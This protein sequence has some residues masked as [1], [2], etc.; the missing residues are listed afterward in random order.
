[1]TDQHEEAER[2]YRLYGAYAS[3]YTGKT[4]S[5]LRKKG[6]P[7]EECLPCTPHFRRHVTPHVGNK[8]IP[9]LEAPD[10]TIVQD[11]TEIFDFIEARHPLPPALPTGP[12]QRLIAHLFELFAD[13]LTPLAWHFRWHFPEENLHFVVRDFGRSFRPQGSD[14]ELERYGRVIAD[15][16]E[17][18][19]HSIGITP[20]LFPALDAIYR[21]VLDHLEAH[22]THYP[23][24]LGGLPCAADFALMGPLFAHL[25][26]DPY[27]L[28]VMQRRAPRVFRW[29][30][31]MNTPE[32]R[33]P[34]F[35][36][37]PQAWLAEDAV[38]QD[39]VALLAMLI[40]D[41]GPLYPASA[42]LYNQWVAEHPDLAEDS[43]V[44]ERGEAQPSLGPVELNLRGEPYTCASA[45][46]GLWILQRSLDHL[47]ALGAD[48]KEACVELA[49]TLGAT[50]LLDVVLSRRLKRA[51]YRL[52]VG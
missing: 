15:Q 35:S 25:G 37:L 44:S 40:R 8:R 49:A 10:G 38:P 39:V 1:M 2:P 3:L 6:I 50:Q 11:S 19:G 9:M 34:E 13:A 45:P 26:R 17:G 5:Y 47:A 42:K 23:Y 29:V 48:D 32:L 24:L 22:F 46:H 16:M 28:H 4:R 52:A 14:A 41:F 21:E 7:F 30:E 12:R 43:P 36:D 31:H 33:M 51:S 20:D 27:P 18:K